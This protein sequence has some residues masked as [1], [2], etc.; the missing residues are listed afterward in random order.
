[1]KY[2][3]EQYSKIGNLAPVDL[4]VNWGRSTKP[5]LGQSPDQAIQ[6]MFGGGAFLAAGPNAKN[7]MPYLEDV[8]NYGDPVGTYCPQPNRWHYVYSRQ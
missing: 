7:Y 3:T 8:K 6:E 1:M 4:T 5:G 2:Q